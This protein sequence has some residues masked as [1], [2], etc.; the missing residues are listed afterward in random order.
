MT[1]REIDINTNDRTLAG[2]YELDIRGTLD[3]TEPTTRTDTIKI[4]LLTILET[5]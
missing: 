2:H 4:T 3:D 5:M 1:N